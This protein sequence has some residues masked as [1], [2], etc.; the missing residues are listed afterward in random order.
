MPMRQ[1]LSLK[2]NSVP[3]ILLFLALSAPAYGLVYT[4]TDTAGLGHYTNKEYEIPARYRSRAKALYPEPGDI[5]T[6]PYNAQSGPEAS[7]VEPVK[8]SRRDVEPPMTEAA[9]KPVPHR[10]ATKAHGWKYR[11]RRSNA[12]TSGE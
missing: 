7:A 10:N 5:P 11:E 12:Q 3:L 8:E 2:K 1:G 4:W 6:V 9:I